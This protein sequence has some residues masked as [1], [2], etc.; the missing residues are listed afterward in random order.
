MEGW[1]V[2]RL[3]EEGRQDS[4]TRSSRWMTSLRPRKPRIASI[5]SDLR[6]LMARMSAAGRRR[7]GADPHVVEV[8][9]QERQ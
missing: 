3:N 4:M 1:K 5:S 2:D 9:V 6:P 8:L 7:R